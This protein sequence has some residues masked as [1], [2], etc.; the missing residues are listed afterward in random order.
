MVYG[1]VALFPLLLAA[2]PGAVSAATTAQTGL[3]DAMIAKVKA[4]L[5]QIATHSWEIGAELEALTELEWPTLAVFEGSLPPPSQ[6]VASDNATDVISIA[7]QVVRNITDPSGPLIDGDGAVGDP[8]SIGQAVLLANWTRTNHSDLSLSYAATNQLNYLLEDAPRSQQGAI[9][10]RADQVQLWADFVYMAPPFIAYYGG[11]QG[12]DEGLSLLKEAYTQCAL[13][14]EHLNNDGSGLWKHIVWGS[15]TDLNHWGTGNGW[16]AAGMLRVLRTIQRSEHAKTLAS[17]TEDLTTWVDEILTAVWKFQHSNGTLF[18]YI[19]QEATTTFADTASTALLAAS[20]Y[21]Y[22]TLTGKFDHIA[23]ASKA[24]D[25]IKASLTDDGW[26]LG[27]TDPLTFSAP[28]KAGTFS[29][30][31]RHSSPVIACALRTP[32]L[33]APGSTAVLRLPPT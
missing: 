33:V 23:A 14:R 1:L 10:Q 32:V 11:M 29:P 30:K 19:D 24:F 28:S 16:G 25:L 15:G 22:A 27:T 26:L 4:N 31:A 21:R 8:A 3:D 2:W 12:G 9:S 6:L 7:T 17:E 5:R 18:N 13:Y 20:S